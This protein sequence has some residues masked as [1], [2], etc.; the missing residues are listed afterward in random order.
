[1]TEVIF[2]SKASWLM[3]KAYM[4]SASSFVCRI[5]VLTKSHAASGYFVVDEIAIGVETLNEL[6]GAASSVGK[7]VK[8]IL[9]RMT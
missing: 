2:L 6:P 7:P 9:S 4:D 3:G 8:V 1:M 5:M